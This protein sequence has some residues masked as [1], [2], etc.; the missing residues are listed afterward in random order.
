[1]YQAYFVNLITGRIFYSSSPKTNKSDEYYPKRNSEGWSRITED[2]YNLLW[3]VR[4]EAI[5]STVK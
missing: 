1:M 5:N 4:N 3:K 2:M